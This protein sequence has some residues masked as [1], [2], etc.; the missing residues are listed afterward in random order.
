MIIPKIMTTLMNQIP[1]DR[2]LNAL[3]QMLFAT[4]NFV[5]VEGVN[6]LLIIYIYLPILFSHFLKSL[7]ELV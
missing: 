7:I 2:A 6:L 1:L 5:L 4:R 3:I